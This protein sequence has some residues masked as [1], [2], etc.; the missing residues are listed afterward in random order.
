MLLYLC[1]QQGRKT[2]VARRPRVGDRLKQ[3]G[4]A[5]VVAQRLGQRSEQRR[6]P[7]TVQARAIGREG[8]LS[9][10]ERGFLFRGWRAQCVHGLRH[11]I[12][13]GRYLLVLW[14]ERR[15]AAEGEECR[16]RQASK[17]HVL[18]ISAKFSPMLKPNGPKVYLVAAV[19]ANG[20]IGRQG[21]LPW[22]LPEDLKHFK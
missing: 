18:I 22:H 6:E 4:G 11:Q 2:T 3:L 15:A 1:A 13:D 14:I 10:G 9:A 21:R 19:A 8:A 16:D 5:A 7:Q 17:L 12:V 20:V